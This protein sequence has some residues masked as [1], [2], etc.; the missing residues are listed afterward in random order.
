MLAKLKVFKS[1]SGGNAVPGG[2][3]SM[4]K[5]KGG[6]I[7]IT[8]PFSSRKARNSS[9]TRMGDQKKKELKNTKRIRGVDIP[10]GGGERIHCKSF[11]GDSF[12]VW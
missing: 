2:K 8:L 10:P 3:I 11:V 12:L 9:Y 7:K 5:R 1:A 4:K 6:K